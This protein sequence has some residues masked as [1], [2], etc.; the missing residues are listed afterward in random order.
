MAEESREKKQLIVRREPRNLDMEDRHIRSEDRYLEID[1]KRIVY[2]T[3][4][5]AHLPQFV[6]VVVPGVVVSEVYKNDHGADVID[7]EPI[8]DSRLQQMVRG[9][10]GNLGT[11]SFW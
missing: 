3:N 5:N 1:R 9:K 4:T 11:L 7:V 2:F 6:G 10:I 8:R